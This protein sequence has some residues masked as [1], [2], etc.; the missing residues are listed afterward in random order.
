MIRTVM[1]ILISGIGL[2]TGLFM[3]IAFMGGVVRGRQS[4]FSE[5]RKI[6]KKVAWISIT[7]TSILIVVLSIYFSI[8]VPSLFV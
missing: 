4:L 3:I 1:L 7:I 8:G 2:M 5:E 6:D